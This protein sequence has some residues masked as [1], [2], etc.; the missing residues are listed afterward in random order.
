MT[1]DVI[2]TIKGI[3]TDMFESEE[4]EVVTTGK[5]VEKNNKIYITYIDSNIDKDKDTKTTIKLEENQISILRFG[6]VNSHMVFEKEKTHITHYQTP[7]GVFEINTFTKEINVD[8]QENSMDINVNYNLSINHMS[9]GT[10]TFTIKVTNA[11][12][13]KII[14][15]DNQK[16]DVDI[17]N[18]EL[19]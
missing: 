2:I 8:K 3:Q 5:Y 19:S 1:K 4:I 11:N 14:L 12:S 16:I 7:Y 9:M 15:V 18:E 10:N 17:E 13:D 6:G